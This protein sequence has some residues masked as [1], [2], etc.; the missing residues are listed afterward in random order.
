MNVDLMLLQERH[1]T[2]SEELANFVQTNFGGNLLTLRQLEPYITEIKR[3]FR[4]L[5]R[6]P[7][8]D[9]RFKTISGQRNFKNWCRAV[10]N[11]TDRCVRYMLAKSR[12]E[13]PRSKAESISAVQRC[14]NYIQRQKLSKEIK[15]Q[16][17]EI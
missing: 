17:V 14:I 2:P 4:V 12:N 5:P 13:A 7:G 11:R 8:V 1:D 15:S 9:G 6:K 3:R 16:L 10:L